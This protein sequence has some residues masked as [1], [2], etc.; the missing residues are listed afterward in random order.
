VDPKAGGSSPLAHPTYPTLSPKK[1]PT[2]RPRHRSAG[3]WGGPAKTSRRRQW[4]GIGLDLPLRTRE[5]SRNIFGRRVGEKPG[6]WIGQ[7]DSQPCL[8]APG[9][10]AFPKKELA[11]S[12]LCPPARPLSLSWPAPGYG[13][14]SPCDA[15]RESARLTR[16]SAAPGRRERPTPRG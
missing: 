15:R 8:R 3:R 11:G 9:T 14:K 6:L 2:R 5:R 16:D 1:S 10:T 7:S 13:R 4:G 12:C